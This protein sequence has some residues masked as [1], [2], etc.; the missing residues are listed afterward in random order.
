M[1]QGEK[2]VC[3]S[4]F[5]EP[6]LVRFVKEQAVAN[7]CSFCPAKDSVPIATSTDTVAE[8]FINCLMQEYDFSV[9]QIGWDGSEGGWTYT[10]WD[11]YEL[12]LDELELE[13]PQGN[14]RE[15]LPY[16]FGEHFDQDWCEANGYGLND[17]EW[18]RYSWDHFLQS[19]YAGAKVLFPE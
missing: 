18:A 7:E 5:E 15:L 19:S 1:H 14:E 6:A 3:V 2:F 17:Q 13:F 9:N 16:L 8:Y 11:A 10:S 12:A 4:C